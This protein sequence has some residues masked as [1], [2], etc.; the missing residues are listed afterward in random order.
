MRDHDA[1]EYSLFYLRADLDRL[2]ADVESTGITV[3]CGNGGPEWDLR[4]LVGLRRLLVSERIAIV[5]THMPYMAAF[6]RLLVR[7]I[8]KSRRPVTVYTEHNT[9][10][11]H[12]WATRMANRLTVGLDAHVFAVSSAV[13]ASMPAR[14][15]ASVEV[16]FHGVDLRRVRSAVGAR[17]RVRAD[18]GVSKGTVVI[19][20][21]ANH[22]AQKGLHHLLASAAIVLAAEPSAVFVQIGDGPLTDELHARHAELGLGG[23][24]R[25]LGRRGDAV[26]LM[27]GMDVYAMS[28]V[29]EG[30]PVAVMEAAVL[31]LPVVAT[32][33]GGLPEMVRTG[34]Q[35]LLVPINDEGGLA[36]ALRKLID[37]DTLRCRMGEAA[38]NGSDRF[39][40]AVTVAK[41]EYT[42]ARLA[43][44]SRPG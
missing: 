10:T 11:S 30:L 14:R 9:W 34:E 43:R 23:R 44:G 15:N 3:K 5:H 18:W 37:D 21:V 26:E 41:L 6:T 8:P 35:G 20:N 7:T 16:L 28:S 32:T 33:A 38:R 22:R 29:T 12:A 27:S 42:Y 40:M 17:S 4:W 31:G 36:A 24:F 19:G 13:R 2:R 39:D 25:F 1:F